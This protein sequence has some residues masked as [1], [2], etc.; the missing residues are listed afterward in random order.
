MDFYELEEEDQL[1]QV[2]EEAKVEEKEEDFK[3]LSISDLANLQKKLIDNVSETLNI[4]KGEAHIL[5]RF[6][7]WKDEKIINLYFENDIDYLLKNA[8]ISKDQNIQ[9]QDQDETKTFECLTCLDDV[10]LS[11]TKLSKCNHRFCKN[12]W[13]MH[14]SVQIK[15]G[16]STNVKC[17]DHKC[18]LF[19]DEEFILDFVQEDIREYYQKRILLSFVEESPF[20]KW[21]PSTPSCGNIIKVRSLDVSS[22][23]CSC[24]Y[25]FW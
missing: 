19:L 11:E 13:K 16:K 15:E 6:Y 9:K 4:S 3:I 1:S 12:C 14:I 5:L 2:I 20:L 23:T 22:I 25:E 10:P 8:G 21:C 18:G 24:Q 17:M 7:G